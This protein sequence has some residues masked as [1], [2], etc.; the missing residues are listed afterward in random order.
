MNASGTQAP[1][2]NLA[3][4]RYVE[5]AKLLSVKPQT[6]RN[7]VCSGKYNLPYIRISPRCVR[8]IRSD[9]ELWIREQGINSSI[10]KR[11][12]DGKR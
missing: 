5:I 11:V 4:M 2:E 8:F 9:I 10:G 7:W 3:L 6:V 1:V 12:L